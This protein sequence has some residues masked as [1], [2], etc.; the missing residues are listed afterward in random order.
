MVPQRLIGGQPAGQR[1]AR[2]EWASSAPMAR[3]A[4]GQG[5]AMPVYFL[6]TGH[7]LEQSARVEGRIREAIPELTRITRVEDAASN[8]ADKAHDPIYVLLVG[9][10]TD[11][12]Y[13]ERLI[14]TASHGHERI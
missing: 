9:P 4:E 14:E 7:S 6:N 10:A 8:R 11:S 2:S 5:Y 1:L 3:V 12:N 13:V